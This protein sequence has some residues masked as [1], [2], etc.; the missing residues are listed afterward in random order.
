MALAPDERN[1]LITQMAEAFDI[2]VHP[3]SILVVSQDLR[4]VM[5]SLLEDQ[6]N[7]VHV[8]AYTELPGNVEIQVLGRFTLPIE[9]LGEAA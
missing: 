3:T 9:E 4:R 6:F 2:F 7:H 5:R 1:T 8:F